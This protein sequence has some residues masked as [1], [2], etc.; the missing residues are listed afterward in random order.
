MHSDILTQ[1]GQK[2]R[3][4]RQGRQLTVQGLASRAGVSKGLISRIENSRTIPSLPVLISLIKALDVEVNTFFEDID[5]AFSEP[6]VV[7]RRRADLEYLMME[8]PAGFS[9]QSIIDERLSNAVSRISV[10][11]VQPGSQGKPQVTDS[12]EFRY[13]LEGEAEY[14]IGD[15]QFVLQAGDSIY[16][17]GNLAHAPRNRTG[18]KLRILVIHFLAIHSQ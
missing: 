9:Y 4:L 16:F 18:Q 10:L 8:K 6:R 17:D 15:Q 5:Q 1:I 3:K 11:E 2:I 13:V 14:E 12:F 7:L